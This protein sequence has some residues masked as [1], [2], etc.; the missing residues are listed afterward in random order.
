MNAFTRRGGN[1]RPL[2]QIVS[3]R[4][5]S[6]DGATSRLRRDTLP[7]R[8][9]TKLFLYSGW[10]RAI[11]R[12]TRPVFVDVDDGFYRPALL[13]LYLPRFLD[14][15]GKGGGIKFNASDKPV[16]ICASTSSSSPST[17][18]RPRQ[19]RLTVG[20]RERRP[21]TRETPACDELTPLQRLRQR[22][23]R[24]DRIWAATARSSKHR[25]T[26]GDVATARFIGSASVRCRVRKASPVS[27]P[28][29]LIPAVEDIGS[30]VGRRRRRR[31]HRRR[32]TWLHAAMDKTSVGRPVE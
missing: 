6:V 26:V 29:P 19:F 10:T 5:A 13:I 16:L 2:E 17:I 20:D 32:R 15:N 30:V 24:S 7:F 27:K 31:R 9:R 3:S 23:R 11:G 1:R 25:S 28:P 22:R 21:E 18:Q 4:P 14:H 12:T 8:L